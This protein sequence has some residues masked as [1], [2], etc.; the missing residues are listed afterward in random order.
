L[1]IERASPFAAN[2]DP[3]PQSTSPGY[4]RAPLRRLSR[5]TTNKQVQMSFGAP[6]WLPLCVRAESETE[7]DV[8]SLRN[9]YESGSEMTIEAYIVI[10]GASF[11]YELDIIV[12]G[13][14]DLA[15]VSLEIVESKRTIAF[16]MTPD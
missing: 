13:S 15:C 9:K 14:N 8:S 1:D 12:I 3:L 4:C 2:R 11:F 7:K 10:P 5:H 6:S 16:W